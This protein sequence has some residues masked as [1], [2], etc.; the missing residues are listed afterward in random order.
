MAYRQKFL[1]LVKTTCRVASAIHKAGVKTNVDNYG[2]VTILPIMEKVFETAVYRR[3]SFVDELLGK[4]DPGF[5]Q[6]IMY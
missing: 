1:K 5:A 6:Q 3:L 2:G 4:V